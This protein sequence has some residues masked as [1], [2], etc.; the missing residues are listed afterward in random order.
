VTGCQWVVGIDGGG[1]KTASAARQLGHDDVPRFSEAG[2]CNVAAMP[3]ETAVENVCASIRLLE[4]APESVIAICAGV[5]GYSALGKRETFEQGLQSKYL[6][7]KLRIVP[8]YTVAHAGNFVT[9]V[10]ISVIGG[11]GSIAYG[12]NDR[13]DSAVCGGYGYLVDDLGTG[14]GLGR[15]VLAAA[16][17]V[18]DGSSDGAALFDLFQLRT[19]IT[20]RE[21]LIASVYGGPLDRVAIAALAPL[22][23][24]AAEAG[25]SSADALLMHAGGALARITQSTIGRLFEQNSPVSVSRTGSLW[26]AGGELNNVFERSVLRAHP[27]VQFVSVNAK[28]EVGALSLARKLLAD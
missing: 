3:V 17:R 20:A 21:Q 11:T 18:Y 6:K 28:P 5:A 2:P 13:G 27:A 10:G 4:I 15:Q 14:Y 12:E 16:G 25:D 8:D 7:A 1:T 22:V 9:G 19:G 23:F 24:E 26:R